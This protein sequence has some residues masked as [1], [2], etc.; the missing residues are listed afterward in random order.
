MLVQEWGFSD[1]DTVFSHE[2]KKV[3][4]AGHSGLAGSAL[5]RRLAGEKCTLLTA[6]HS[7]L[8]LTNQEAVS[9]W[10]ISNS[11]DVVYLAAATAGGIHANY[12]RPG[13][14]IYNNLAIQNNV[15]HASYIHGVKKLCF[16]GSS[17]IY[18]RLAPQP[19]TEKS[20]LTGSLDKHN[21]WYAVAKIAGLMLV[22]GYSKQYGCD[23]ISVMPANLYG[24]GDKYTEKN[25]HV[26]AALI[27]RFHE[28]KLSN[29]A[30]VSI[31]GTGNAMRE[32]LHCDDMADACVYLMENYT[33]PDIVNIGTGLDLSIKDLAY[34]IKDVVGFEGN[35]V[36][37]TSKPDG[38]PRKVVDVSKLQSIGW[39]SKISL[40]AGIAS[41]YE[42]Y[43]R[44]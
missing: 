17:C 11:P 40:R 18:P 15:V 38:M 43:L 8:D 42:E 3:Y 14:F 16:L 6:S 4:V 7:E 12:E 39:Q 35:V 2:G 26:V 22:D 24:P 29:D 33:S 36:F 31:W 23:F 30:S 37:D 32:F 1:M 21:V 19:M 44:L 9:Q 5:V 25:S 28:A 20:L 27:K 10:F 34:L 13:E 41:T